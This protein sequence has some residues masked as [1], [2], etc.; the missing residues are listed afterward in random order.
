MRSELDELVD[1]LRDLDAR[2]EEM[3]PEAE[4]RRELEERRLALSDRVEELREGTTTTPPQP[5]DDVPP[6]T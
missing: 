4:D 1:E 3:P 5:E 2:L 6:L